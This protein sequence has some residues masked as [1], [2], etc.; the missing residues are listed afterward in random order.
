M[1]VAMQLASERAIS[2]TDALWTLIMN[3]S[4]TIQQS[5]AKRLET[6]LAEDKRQAQEKYV[7]ES[8]T[9]AMNEVRKAHIEGHRL[10][11]AR[12]LIDALDE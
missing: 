3:Q 9:C 6:H 11:D 10:P 5:L 4:K 1:A 8:L 2:T 12:N 7:R